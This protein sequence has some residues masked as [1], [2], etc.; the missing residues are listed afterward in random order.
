V[1]LACGAL[2]ALIPHSS[3]LLVGALAVGSSM[4]VMVVTDTEHPP[5]SGTALGTAIT[6]FSWQA[7]VA[8]AASAVLLSLAHY[9]LRRVLRDLT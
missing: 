1:G 2:C 4:F 8:V 3:A 6:G 9:L 7:G 5:A